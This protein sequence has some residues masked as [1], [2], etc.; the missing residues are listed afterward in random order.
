M[1]SHLCI[2]SPKVGGTRWRKLPLGSYVKKTYH[3]TFPGKF[4]PNSEPR[5]INSLLVAHSQHPPPPYPAV[6]NKRHPPPPH[7]AK[8]KGQFTKTSPS[9]FSTKPANLKKQAL[10][11]VNRPSLPLV[12]NPKKPVLSTTL[13]SLDLPLPPQPEVNFVCNDSCCSTQ[14]NNFEH[15]MHSASCLIIYTF[16]YKSQCAK[17]QGLGDQSNLNDYYLERKSTTAK[18]E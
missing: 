18:N 17:F 15:H 12:K 11:A 3:A 16:F 7:V 13:N 2:S 4:L 9:S 14:V 6:A 8:V 10:T 1:S 5:Q